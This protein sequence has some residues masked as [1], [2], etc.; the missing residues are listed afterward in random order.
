MTTA[1]ID[2]DVLLKTACYG[3]LEK[4]RASL[5][6]CRVTPA[7]LGMSRFTVRARLSKRGCCSD[8]A[9][10]LKSFDVF[11]EAA[12]ILEPSDGEAELAAEI[13][14]IAQQA[15]ASLDGGE[16]QLAAIVLSRSMHALITGDKRATRA[17]ARIRHDLPIL[18]SLDGLVYCLEQVLLL[19]LK[20]LPAEEVR[21]CVCREPH[22]DSALTNSFSCR[23]GLGSAEEWAAGLR[24]YIDSLRS[25]SPGVLS[26]V[27]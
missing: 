16:S 26:A 24:S 9:G 12:E 18:K 4:T 22:V 6:S 17:F 3:L 19:L 8:S 5:E 25:E 13:E 14:A 20:C 15:A 1:A 23:S 27:S 2:A 10:A 11:L 21:D 7:A